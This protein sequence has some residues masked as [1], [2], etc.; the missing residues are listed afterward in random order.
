MS[1]QVENDPEATRHRTS[2]VQQTPKLMSLLFPWDFSL[3]QTGK[4]LS[5]P[6]IPLAFKLGLPGALVLR[7]SETDVMRFDISS[8]NLFLF[9][10]GVGWPGRSVCS[11]LVMCQ[12]WGSLWLFNRPTSHPVTWIS[13]AETPIPGTRFGGELQEGVGHKPSTAP[14]YTWTFVPKLGSEEGGKRDGVKT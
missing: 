14:R 8:R 10:H 2:Q 4:H 7:P 3:S 6:S 11:E 9:I 12:T 5:H 13:L 1:G